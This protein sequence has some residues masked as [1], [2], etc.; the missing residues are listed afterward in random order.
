MNTLPTPRE[1]V[2]LIEE[3]TSFEYTIG[4]GDNV[5][6]TIDGQENILWVTLDDEDPTS[7]I[8]YVMD[9]LH[10]FREKNKRGIYEMDIEYTVNSVEE[11]IEVI[12]EIEGLGK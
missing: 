1:I 12:K 11:V 10:I 2:D 4:D 7:Y 3:Q 5:G 6:G 8:V 9:D